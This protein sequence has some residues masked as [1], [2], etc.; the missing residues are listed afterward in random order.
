[1]ST[2]APSFDPSATR[3][4]PACDYDLRAATADRCPECGTLIGSID[5]TIPWEHRRQLGRF[6]AFC[7]TV[8]FALRPARLARSIAEPVDFFSARRFAWIA[9]I[10]AAIPLSALFI[11]L[12][13]INGFPDPNSWS[14]GPLSRMSAG[15]T[16]VKTL[17]DEFAYCWTVGGALYPVLPIGLLITLFLWMQVP[18]CWFGSRQLSLAR[19]QRATTLSYYTCAPIA[20]LFIPCAAAGFL[21]AAQQDNWYLPGPTLPILWLL[22][23]TAPLILLLWWWNILRL[24]TQFAPGRHGILI[25]AILGIPA[26]F[27]LSI[28][29]GCFAFPAV[30]GLLRIMFNSLTS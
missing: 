17:P 8:R 16:I 27:A 7:R 15:A 19:R 26:I 29:I 30:V 11:L 23:L 25:T 24:L 9:F 1:M 2:P 21:S 13:G 28:A 5:C 20:L 3:P 12:L 14:L 18:T 10:L 6:R 22:C 4:C